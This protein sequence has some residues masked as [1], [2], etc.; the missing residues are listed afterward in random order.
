MSLVKKRKSVSLSMINKEGLVMVLRDRLRDG[1]SARMLPQT[2]S[3]L[4]RNDR[5]SVCVRFPKSYS[6][7]STRSTLPRLRT[8]DTANLSDQNRID[9]FVKCGTIPRC[10]IRGEGPEKVGTLMR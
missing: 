6:P 5:R 9:V 8:D 4:T 10:D 7:S 1:T 3:K 2:P